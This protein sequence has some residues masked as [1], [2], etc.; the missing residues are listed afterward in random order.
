MV[1]LIPVVFAVVRVVEDDFVDAGGV[2]LCCSLLIVARGRLLVHLV[3][4]SSTER[5]AHLRLLR[6]RA[7]EQLVLLGEGVL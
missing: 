5:D 4:L 3:G 6:L 2:S 7:G 1:P